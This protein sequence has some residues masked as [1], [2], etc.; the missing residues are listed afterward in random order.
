M[1][2]DNFTPRMIRALLPQAPLGANLILGNSATV[3]LTCD[4]YSKSESDGRYFSNSD[5]TPLDSRYHVVNGNAGG[6]GII[7]MVLDNFTPRMIRA[8]L[9]QAPLGANLILGNSATV[10]LTCDCYSKAESDARYALAGAPPS[11]P[12]LV[13]DV[14]ANGADFLTLR[15]GNLGIEFEASNGAAVADLSS[16]QF[17]LKTGVNMLTMGRIF[18]DSSLGIATAGSIQADTVEPLLPTNQ[19][20]NLKAGTVSVTVTDQADQSLCT[21][22]TAEVHS[23]APRLRVDTEL[24]IDD[25]TGTATGLVT[26]AISTRVQDTE[27]TITGGSGGTIVNGALD[28][29]GTLTSGSVELSTELRAPTV[30]AR[31]TDDY[32]TLTG[33][34]QGTYLNSVLYTASAIRAD[35][36][37]V[38]SP[39]YLELIGGSTG[40]QAQGDLRVVATVNSGDVTAEVVNLAP[41]GNAKL[42][43]ECG[44]GEGELEA[45]S[46]GG[47]Q[48]FAPNQAIFF[49][50][51]SAG[52]ANL[53]VESNTGGV[54]DGEVIVNYGFQNLSDEKLKHSVE[55][56]G[57]EELQ[58][59]FD[60]V[61]PKW[62][63]RTQGSQKRTL[64]FIANEVQET[65]PVGQALCGK[66]VDEELG[67]LTTLDYN[68]MCCVLWGVCQGLQV[69]VEALEK[70][71]K[72]RGRS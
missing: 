4:C 51:S 71:G 31:P 43:L 27:L 3:Q 46:A 9:P 6:G 36:G 15:G 67:E 16:S 72:K 59:L 25:A 34:T 23:I 30:R 21:F 12:L 65:G 22:A 42:R 53:I 8:L 24:Y 26:N 49:R 50:T 48:L 64:G 20:L 35:N 56:A 44:S 18:A 13:N 54:N 70:K 32:L 37:I 60:A 66:L 57:L 5:F 40:V 58:E 1:V 2:L 11:D 61:A 7:P 47:V 10:Q 69:R 29:Q 19:F 55:P 38:S 63:R 17:S 68:R 62:Y 41:V 39:A 52:P 14:R 33:G 45:A 28:V